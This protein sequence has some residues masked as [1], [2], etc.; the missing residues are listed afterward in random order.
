MITL[1][2]DLWWPEKYFSPNHVLKL[3]RIKQY[4]YASSRLREGNRFNINI[5]NKKNIAPYDREEHRCIE[6]IYRGLFSTKKNSI[7]YPEILS[8]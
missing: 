7:P 1:K 4:S 5:K 3:I 6:K 2:S 8:S